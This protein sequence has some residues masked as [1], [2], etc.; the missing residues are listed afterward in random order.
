M[1]GP[2][3]GTFL[4][5]TQQVTVV[6]VGIGL[7]AGNSTLQ[8]DHTVVIGCRRTTN[9]NGRFHLIWVANRPLKR[10]LRTP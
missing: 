4:Q 10:L 2:R 5:W 1:S 7:Q 9:W 8:P 6:P 3:L